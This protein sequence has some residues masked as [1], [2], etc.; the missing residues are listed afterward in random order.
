MISIE[1]RAPRGKTAVISLGRR[2]WKT[3]SRRR[4]PQT[5]FRP[6]RFSHACQVD[7]R[8]STEEL[9]PVPDWS[10]HCLV[11]GLSRTSPNGH[12]T[13]HVFFSLHRRS[14]SPA[15]RNQFRL[16]SRSPGGLPRQMPLVIPCS[17]GVSVQ[18]QAH[19]HMHIFLPCLTVG[20]L[21][22]HRP[23]FSV[24]CR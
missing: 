18:Q 4:P 14:L 11:H 9:R 12:P 15:R 19:T 1:L 23:R 7:P 3:F 22:A 6:S 8:T 17:G 21:G 10:P 13:Q 20:R 16:R 5:S 24:W 2:A